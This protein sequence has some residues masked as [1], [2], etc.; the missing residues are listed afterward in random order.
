MICPPAPITARRLLKAL[1]SVAGRNC[2]MPAPG[3]SP[4][5]TRFGPFELD[6]T[7]G[8]L[9]KDGHKLV[10][11]PKAFEILK[12]LLERPGEVVTREQL[13]T[14]L[15]A[16]DTFVEFDDSLNHAVKK[17]R[18]T[19]GDSAEEPEFIETLPRHGYRLIASRPC[20]A[21][22]KMGIRSLAV[23]PL[24]S[25]SDDPR[26][27]Y[28]ADG[29]TDT[30]IAALST[31]RAVSV[32]SRTSVMRYKGVSKRLPHIAR[33]LKVDAVLEGT[34]QRSSGRVRVTV[35]LIEAATDTHLWAATYE[36][37]FRDVLLLQRDVARA[38][39][40]EIE[41]ALTPEESTRLALASP[42]TPEAYEAYL[43]GQFHWYS[44]S[45]GRL[46]RALGYF[47]LALEKDPA[48]ALAHAGIGNVWLMRADAGSMPPRAALPKAREAI[49]KA[50][51]LDPALPEAHVAFGNI[52]ALYEWDW[53]AAEREFRRA[54]ELNPNSADGHLMYADFLLSMR[55][56]EH[57]ASEARRAMDLDPLSPF[58]QCFY[59]WHLV[60]LHQCEDAIGRLRKALAADP[61]FPSA[62]MGL[63][64]A[65]YRL[66]HPDDALAAA[67]EFF[68]LLG[69]REVEDALERGC[70]GDGYA[71]AMHL[72]AEILA[73]RS[74]RCH[75]PG[76]RVARLY[77]HAGENDQAMEWLQ[78]AWEQRETPLVHL[79]VAWDWD[80][81]REDSRF[82]DL[83]RRV[84]LPE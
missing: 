3:P 11:P 23:L 55:R 25:L 52:L 2:P 79:G 4:S 15:W 26:Q 48:C 47:Q 24:A 7:S 38:V 29:M 83:L 1:Y 58:F 77:A 35:Q 33:E 75:V 13:R 71:R 80:A 8:E 76:V 27:E 10:L 21:K 61:G 43:K 17:L 46:D 73:E 12:A 84:G 40:Q 60:Y 54:I 56:V 44:L 9:F 49:L 78:R 41:V 67:R 45:P 51:E 59:A 18:H 22:P 74:R 31:I 39:A 72:A 50:L 14:R 65:Y 62:H 20:A 69:D 16:A 30:L 57:W 42:V 34:V 82:R 36:R 66:G 5:R 19:L 70:A 68:S 63:W 64:G 53:P 32:I 37:A 6:S 28:F 81:L